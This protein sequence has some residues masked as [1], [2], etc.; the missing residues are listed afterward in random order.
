MNIGV[1]ALQGAFREHRLVL[2]RLGV[3]VREV[4]LPEEL[5]GCDGLVLPGGET[6]AQRRLARVYGLWEPLRE[7]GERGVPILGTCAGLILMATRV[8]LQEGL[9]LALMD[10]DVKR[11]A[12]G[13]QVHSFEAYVP[14][15]SLE[16]ERGARPLKA[17]FIRAP[18]IVRVGPEVAILA[19]YDNEPVAVQQGSLLA[20]SF[21][22]E[23][24]SDDRLHRYFLRLVEMSL[25]AARTG[26][27]LGS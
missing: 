25:S 6:T 2:E 24:T 18:R 7:M 17:I 23:L 5:R 9:S 26:A 1:L 12:Y 27:M 3:S 8:D 19:R 22:P 11:N 10:I 21:H 16:S 15:R 13:R 4:R 20:T 14:L